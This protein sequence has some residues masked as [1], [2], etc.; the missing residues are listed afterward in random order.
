VTSEL[1]SLLLNNRKQAHR[2]GT[3]Q[4]HGAVY[5]APTE[6]GQTMESDR[7]RF[8]KGAAALSAAPL[9]VPQRVWGANDTP[10]Y[11]LIA[12]G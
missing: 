3:A 8:L 1:Y 6:G 11:G 2:V 5:N 4:T 9:F 10:S 12:A 7:R